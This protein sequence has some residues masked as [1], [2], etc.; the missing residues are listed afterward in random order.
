MDSWHHSDVTYA[1][2]EGLVKRGLLRGRTK[3]VEWPVS[4]REEVLAP[5]DGYDVSFAP[6]HERRLMIPPHPFFRGLL[7]HYQIELQHQ[8]PNGIQH[9]IAFIALCEGYLGIKPHFE[10]W[11]YFFSTPCTRKGREV[12]TYR[13]RWD[14]LVFTSGATGPPST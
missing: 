10:L 11:R 7:H 1:H 12:G 9:I 4:G 5:P 2:M 14:A 3:V 8:N 13:C 6:F